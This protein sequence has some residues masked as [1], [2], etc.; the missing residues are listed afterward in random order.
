MRARCFDPA[1]KQPR[2]VS[3]VD[4]LYT[5]T[6]VLQIASEA[7]MRYAG[8]VF[9]PEGRGGAPPAGENEASREERKRA[10]A[11]KKRAGKKHNAQKVSLA[12]LSSF[13][14]CSTAACASLP[15]RTRQKVSLMGLH[16]RAL[17]P[18]LCL[19]RAAVCRAFRS[20]SLSAPWTSASD[21]DSWLQ[22]EVALPPLDILLFSSQ[23]R[24]AR[25]TIVAH[26]PTCSADMCYAICR[27]TS[28]GSGRWRPAA[29]QRCRTASPRP[30]TRRP[31]R[32]ALTNP[33]HIIACSDIMYTTGSLRW[34][35]RRSTCHAQC[36]IP[37]Q[38]NPKRWSSHDEASCFCNVLK[39]SCRE[40]LLQEARKARKGDQRSEF[41]KSSK[42]FAKVQD[43][44]VTFAGTF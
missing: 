25:G 32:S 21:S 17:Q 23:L 42:M 27:S 34:F 31:T 30:Q 19:L 37:G 35:S 2:T 5:A 10:R 4:S 11:A 40:S 33:P 1:G 43:Q 12:M 24:A 15:T 9:R 36:L 38:Q 28:G 13:A 8:E 14:N 41:T 7:G 20:I 22:M 44:Q 39:R 3:R 16:L 6:Y 29:P 26:E 18:C